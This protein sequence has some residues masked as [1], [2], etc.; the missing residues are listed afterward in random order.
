MLEVIFDGPNLNA[1]TAEVHA[2]LPTLWSVI[3]E[4]DATCVVL[5]RGAR[6]AFSAGGNFDLID[7]QLADHGAL[8]RVLRETRDLVYAMIDFPKPVISAARM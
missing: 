6:K 2:A 8:M 7:E 3:R 5:A 4:D 1:V